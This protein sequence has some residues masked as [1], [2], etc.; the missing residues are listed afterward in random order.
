MAL[1]DHVALVRG[2]D[3]VAALSAWRA[4]HPEE[5]FDLA[6]ADLRG[7]VLVSADLAGANCADADLDGADLRGAD[8]RGA[9][10][11]RA[12]L[13][14]AHLEGAV[15]D[16]ATL[17]EADLRAASA[18]GASFVDTPSDSA[19]FD[20]AILRDAR[21]A[22]ASLEG[23][24]FDHALL[25]RADLERSRSL[26]AHQLRGACVTSAKL[27]DD[28]GAF[29]ALD[30]VAALT[31]VAKGLLL[32]TLAAT[33]Y[34]LLTLGVTRARD[35]L[36]H[37][38]EFALPLF[39]ADVP[40]VAFF[41]IAPSALFVTFIVLGLALQSL[42]EVA[43]DLPAYFPDG[44]PL[45][46]RAQPSLL[47][48]LIRLHV[49]LLAS[50]TWPFSRIQGR[51]TDLLAYRV[52]PLAFATTWWMCLPR[53]SAAL[54]VFLLALTAATFGASVIFA[55]LG[56]GT[57]AGEIVLRERGVKNR[58]TVRGRRRRLEGTIAATDGDEEFA[59]VTVAVDA[60]TPESARGRPARMPLPGMSHAA[61]AVVLAAVV[62]TLP[63]VASLSTPTAHALE[64]PDEVAGLDA[65]LMG[66]R[67]A[68][69]PDLSD[70]DFEGADLRGRAFPRA[71]FDRSR[72]RAVRLDRADLRYASLIQVD[73]VGIELRGAD[74]S[75]AYLTE[76][77]FTGADL[78]DVDL[79]NASI[80]RTRLAGAR[81]NGADLHGV[82]LTGVDLS[83]TLGLTASQIMAAEGWRAARLPRTLALMLGVTDGVATFR[84][85][86]QQPSAPASTTPSSDETEP[87]SNEIEKY[88]GD[89]VGTMTL[90]DGT[91][92]Q[93]FGPG[94]NDG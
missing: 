44:T 48:A 54:N 72:L 46:K 37:G 50:Y 90:D 55:Q 92:L 4:E 80:T 24:R 26:L 13:A 31:R 89:A 51:L 41:F 1:E 49:P 25:T 14:G 33:A 52:V 2:D 40:F 87:V 27:P 38:A 9:D 84:P 36:G 76:G 7:V 32:T 29:S 12:R 85:Y 47:G 30:Q 5:R 69:E 73:A 91:V 19:R 8:L 82:D 53:Q 11:S 15:F 74:L 75:H 45:D 35:V 62:M 71:T 56:A 63:T 79:T 23:T 42:W 43:A 68:V 18:E 20:H 58:A 94:A 28:V 57:L 6:G 21:F 77:D 22:G 70:G 10:F 17:E 86:E 59:R 81:L 3:P 83:D 65:V 61:G 16:G 60:A 64:R 39:G 78:R 93:V 88:T 66:V 34:M 67:G